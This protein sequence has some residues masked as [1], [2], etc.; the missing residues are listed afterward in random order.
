M[1]LL[2]FSALIPFHANSTSL[3]TDNLSTSLKITKIRQNASKEINSVKKKVL[4]NSRIGLMHFVYIG[5]ALFGIYPTLHWIQLHGGISN[6]HVI[7]NNFDF[8]SEI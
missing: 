3:K 8:F 1:C 4:E 7:V 2:F 5:L 6:P